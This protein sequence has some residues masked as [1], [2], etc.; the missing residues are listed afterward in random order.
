MISY[1]GMAY[2]DN[3]PTDQCLAELLVG[4]SSYIHY[5]PA[6]RIGDIN[7]PHFNWMIGALETGISERFTRQATPYRSA[8]LELLINGFVFRKRAARFGIGRARPIC[9]KLARWP[10]KPVV[11]QDL[12]DR[13]TPWRGASVHVAHAGQNPGDHL[14]LFKRRFAG[15]IP[16][17]G[18]PLEAADV[19]ELL[20]AAMREV[21]RDPSLPTVGSEFVMMSVAPWGQAT[22]TFFRDVT[23]TGAEHVAY[24]P[25]VITR[26]VSR[27]PQY[28]SGTLPTI[29]GAGES[30][31]VSFRAV[32]SLTDPPAG[33]AMS[34]GQPRTPP[35][36][37]FGTGF[38]DEPRRLPYGKPTLPPLETDRTPPTET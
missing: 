23:G 25:W 19:E 6:T 9:L 13:V 34:T 15:F 38:V 24:S 35:P 12:I 7:V 27:P 11:R 10:G 30:A 1:S 2:V 29:G 3:L 26:G 33:Y 21:A 18:R 32:P 31:L 28:L 5:G 8:G 16:P 14:K 36:K 4:P 17:E 22:V 20:V 37:L